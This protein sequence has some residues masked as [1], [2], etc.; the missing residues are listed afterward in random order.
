MAVLE[1]RKKSQ[2]TIP[3]E[4]VEGLNLREGD[5]LEVVQ[6]DGILKLIPVV[7]YPKKYISQLKA[8]IDDA[9]EAIKNGE[10]PV[11]DSVE[12]LFEHLNED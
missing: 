3:K 1:L 11:F 5:K 10:L 8:Q 12:A 7:V 6:Q 4:Y 9:K 2:I